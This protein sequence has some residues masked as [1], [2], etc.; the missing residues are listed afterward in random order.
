[1]SD[2]RFRWALAVILFGF[3]LVGALHCNALILTQGDNAAYLYLAESLVTGQGY[4]DIYLVEPRPN[5]AYPPVLPLM[6]TP[7]VAAFGFYV[8]LLKFTVL[9]S[10]FVGLYFIYRLVEYECDR[11]AALFV[12]LLSATLPLYMSYATTVMSEVP[13]ICMSIAALLFGLRYLV[14]S[15]RFSRSLVIAAVFVVAACFTRTIG[16]ALIGAVALDWLVNRRNREGLLRAVLLCGPA[17]LFVAGWLARKSAYLTQFSGNTI[18]YRNSSDL[19]FVARMTGRIIGNTKHYVQNIPTMFLDDGQQAS[20]YLSESATTVLT[21]I[22]L[23]LGLII[24]I[25]IGVGFL[26]RLWSRHSIVECYGL[27]NVMILSVWPWFDIRFYVPLVPIFMLYFVIG[28]RLVV[29]RVAHLSNRRLVSHWPLVVLCVPVVGIAML[30]A[31]RKSTEPEVLGRWSLDAFS[32]FA[33]FAISAVTIAV[34]LFHSRVRSKVEKYATT[35]GA[36]IATTIVV[37][38]AVWNLGNLL[39]PPWGVQYEPE[40][41]S[42]HAAMNYLRENSQPDCVVV[43]RKPRSIYLWAARRTGG[44]PLERDNPQEVIR[45]W[46]THDVDFLVTGHVANGKELDAK[47]VIPAIELAGDEIEEV[48]RD[49]DARVFKIHKPLGLD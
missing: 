6:L 32:V 45:F 4:A 34:G 43:G 3:L 14:G 11:Q 18:Q 15:D 25:V 33:V 35:H 21:S 38:M 47:H 27:C 9:V 48:F 19:P 10:G 40:Y 44:R 16:V 13:Y 49:G 8:P 24:A 42:Y 20:N 22:S 17:T 39:L 12:T 26:H 28:V 37:M 41:R 36:A 2:R 31:V 46:K 1:M 30:L 5:S 29:D 7:A 23:A